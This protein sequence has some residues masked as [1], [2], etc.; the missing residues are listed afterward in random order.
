[1]TKVI[2]NSPLAAYSGCTLAEIKL[3]RLTVNGD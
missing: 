2:W 1:M 3:R